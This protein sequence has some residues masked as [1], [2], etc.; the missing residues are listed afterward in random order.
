MRQIKKSAP[1]DND[2]LN[3]LNKDG[4]EHIDN[5]VPDPVSEE[6]AHRMMEK[7]IQ[8]AL[9]RRQGRKHKV[10]PVIRKFAF[11]AVALFALLIVLT[12]TGRA[13]AVEAVSGVVHFFNTYIFVRS[14]IEVKTIQKAGEVPEGEYVFSSV[15]GAAQK[16]GYPL[17]GLEE[18]I[19]S[20]QVALNVQAAV[21]NILTAYTTTNGDVL[22]VTEIVH[23]LEDTD[24][25]TIIY[26]SEDETPIIKKLF[27]GMDIYIVSNR[28]GVIGYATWDNIELYVS[29]NT[30]PIEELSSYIE[31]LHYI[32]N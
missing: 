16:L 20:V 11:S 12:P 31:Q 29:S 6:E 4:A 7:S 30:M 2:M 1:I 14:K 10:H 15:E 18:G 28:D 25:G 24:F 21:D 5:L 32:N 17:M 27:N 3:A 8:N 9:T 13:L 26:K 19:L 22:N 23:E